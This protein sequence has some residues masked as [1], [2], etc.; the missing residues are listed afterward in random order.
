MRMPSGFTTPGLCR[1]LT[2]SGSM[3][4]LIGTVFTRSQNR[5]ARPSSWKV[6]PAPLPRHLP[7]CSP[8]QLNQ[9]HP[10]SHLGTNLSN[11]H[12]QRQSQYRSHPHRYQHQSPSP[13]LIK[14]NPQPVQVTSQRA[15]RLHLN[16][17]PRQKGK[18]EKES[19][20]RL[21]PR[22]VGLLARSS[23]T[24]RM[25]RQRQSHDRYQSPLVGAIYIMYSRQLP[26][27]ILISYRK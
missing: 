2:R 17:K 8:Y 14:R 20:W 22:R 11:P 4:P 18:R 16:P 24:P 3:G 19:R 9:R 10:L 5:T 26:W 27:G 15:T 1:I 6:I 21:G 7:L 25:R 23:S 12:L 13:S